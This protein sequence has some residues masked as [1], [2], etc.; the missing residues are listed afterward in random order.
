MLSRLVLL[1]LPL[2]KG[3]SLLP[4]LELDMLVSVYFAKVLFFSLI[5]FDNV[6]LLCCIVFTHSCFLV[7]TV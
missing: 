5:F 3:V 7:P 2:G 6:T 4:I 1:L